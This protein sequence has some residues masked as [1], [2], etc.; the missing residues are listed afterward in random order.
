MAVTLPLGLDPTGDGAA[1]P[2]VTLPAEIVAD[3]EALG[4]VGMVFHGGAYGEVCAAVALRERAQAPILGALQWRPSSGPSRATA[5]AAERLP[6]AETPAGFQIWYA[7]LPAELPAVG[8]T[9]STLLTEASDSSAPGRRR[10]DVRAGEPEVWNWRSIQP[11]EASAG[12]E[13][14]TRHRKGT[15]DRATSTPAAAPGH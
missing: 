2:R 15:R 12:I 9:L 11:V 4:A 13:P 1:A 7:C 10:I 8:A 6:V 14:K 3:A 5:L